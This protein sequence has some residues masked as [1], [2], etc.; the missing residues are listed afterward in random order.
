MTLRRFALYAIAAALTISLFGTVA[1]GGTTGSLVGTIADDGRNGAPI[2]GAVVTV[3]SPSQVE[4]TVTDPAGHFSF[5]SLA[6]GAYELSASRTRYQPT[7]VSVNITADA[8]Q[9]VYVRL[10]PLVAVI[11]RLYARPVPSL[12]HRAGTSDPYE[13]QSTWPFYSFDGHD[14]YALHFIPGLTFGSGPVL[15]R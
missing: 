5:V 11:E 6:P 3:S 15:S 13:V 14:T 1:S 8:S 12:V 9:S 2:S 10:Q 7:V 4:R